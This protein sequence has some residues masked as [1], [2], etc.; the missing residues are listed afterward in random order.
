MKCEKFKS[1]GNASVSL[2]YSNSPG[3]II[4]VSSTIA[5][6]CALS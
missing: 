5:G 2:I 1:F 4:I 3:L 6:V